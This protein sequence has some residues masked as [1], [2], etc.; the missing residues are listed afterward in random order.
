M[1]LQPT[2]ETPF[3]PDNTPYDAMG[4]EPEVRA[5]VDAFYDRV[6][7]GAPDLRALYPEDLVEP[8][9]KLF[10]FL[11]GWLGGPPLYMQKRG[12]P[13]LRVRHAHLPIDQ[14]M[15]DAWLACMDGAMEDRSIEG[16]LREF[17][18]LRLAHTANF[19]RNC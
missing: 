1:N 2:I 18:R 7:N 5:F 6:E 16:P 4:G 8:R 15:A 12:H 14:T 9:Q 17:L 13:R 10:E 19:M 11:S 3:G